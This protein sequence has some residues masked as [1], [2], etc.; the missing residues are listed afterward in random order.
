MSKQIEIYLHGLSGAGK[1]TIADYL[2]DN[3]NFVKLRI[4]KTIKQIIFE[5]RGFESQNQF[6]NYKRKQELI[7]KEHNVWGTILDHLGSVHSNRRASLNRLE[8]LL[9]GSANDYELICNATEFNRVFVDVRSQDELEYIINKRKSS[10]TVDWFIIFLTRNSNEYRDI[11]HHT[12]QHLN[13][14]SY[15]EQYPD[16]VFIIDNKEFDKE[17]LLNEFEKVYTQILKR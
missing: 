7:R 17:Q 11:K 13:Y 12:E 16:N 5:T 6:E 3:K 9:N 10:E 2:R 8:S 4:A 15:L 14:V 1:D